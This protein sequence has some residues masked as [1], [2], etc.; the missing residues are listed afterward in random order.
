MAVTQASNSLGTLND[1]PALSR[2]AH[3]LGAVIVVDGAQAAPHRPVDV[4][5]LGCDFYAISGHK[6]C[7]PGVGRAVGPG[8]AARRGWIRS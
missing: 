4:Q 7:G 8:G 2:W 6:M 1:I 3:E 5:A